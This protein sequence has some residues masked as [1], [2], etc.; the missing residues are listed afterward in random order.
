MCHLLMC[1]FENHGMRR[2]FWRRWYLRTLSAG[3]AWLG[4]MLLMEAKWGL[5][6][7]LLWAALFSA[8]AIHLWR[9]SSARVEFHA[10]GIEIRDAWSRTFVPWS[11]FRRFKVDES[12]EGMAGHIETSD[13][14]SIRVAVLIPL[15]PISRGARLQPVIDRANEFS[16][17]I[18]RRGRS[19]DPQVGDP[20]WL[21]PSAGVPTAWT[22]GGGVR[23][24]AVFTANEI[25]RPLWYRMAAGFVGLGLL[26]ASAVGITLLVT[27][28]SFSVSPEGVS[29]LCLM[30]FLA[31]GVGRSRVAFLQE[32]VKVRNGW[33]KRLV[34][35]REF[36]RLKVATW[37]RK[38]AGYLETTRGQS[39]RVHVLSPLPLVHRRIDPQPTVD[40]ANRL[41]Q[42]HRVRASRAQP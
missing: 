22:P 12:R 19:D 1:E 25:R 3:A 6:W 20:I 17:E 2:P 35:W 7:R 37:E 18:R 42:E 24:I 36:E 33:S 26:L 8:W 40:R 13:G 32:G 11:E 29:S 16:E 41:A 23:E 21:R 39:I 38:R 15:L 27:G 5:P 10:L 9:W 34:P 14:G 31:W 28:S 4:L 30:A